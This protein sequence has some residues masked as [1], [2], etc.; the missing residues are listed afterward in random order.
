MPEKPRFLTFRD[1]NDRLIADGRDAIRSREGRAYRARRRCL[2]P[3]ASL[4]F[5][6]KAGSFAFLHG[7]TR[8][9]LIMTRKD[10][11]KKKR[12]GGTKR[13]KA[14]IASSL[15]RRIGFL[16]VDDFPDQ[17]PF[18]GLPTQ[19]YAPHRIVRGKD[20]ELFIVKR[21]L[22]E[23]W[24]IH[25]DLLVKKLPQGTLFGEMRLLGQTMV[26]TQAQAS[27]AGAVVAVMNVG[28]VRELIQANALPL[29]EKLYPVLASLN[30]EHYRASFQRVESRLAALLLEMAGDDS[31]VRGITQ[32]QMGESIGVM[33]ETVTVA[34]TQ[35]KDNRIITIGRMKTVIND[36][37]ALEELSQM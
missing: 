21:G 1:G 19:S 7:L 12:H 3:L 6:R 22:V 18:D 31:I 26:T 29:A 27:D 28:Q 37:K 25:H 32:R 17:S 23:V 9:T 34:L 4:S 36:R 14:L 15:A 24:H 16:T 20:S 13:T 8:L 30:I 2:L 11:R 35:L 10:T 5:E 33:R